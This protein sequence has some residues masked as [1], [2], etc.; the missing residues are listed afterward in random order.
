MDKNKLIPLRECINQEVYLMYQDI[1]KQEIGSTNICNGVSYEEFE[2][3]CKEYVKEEKIINPELNTT[4]IRYILFTSGKPVGEVGIRT[5]LND[6]WINKG[7]Q[8]FYKIKKSE[9]GK[10]YGNIILNLA[11]I[12]AKKLGF[13][14]VRVNCNNQN[15]PSQKTII[16]NGGK[17][18]I[19]DYTTK[20]GI[21]SS[22]IINLDN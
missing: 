21:S 10:G 4:T 5:I 16:K 3:I 1:P 19:K 2:N 12:E 14:Q 13:K 15:I 9:R 17:L 11:L 6:F 20:E 7:S 22:Y 8:I 18:D